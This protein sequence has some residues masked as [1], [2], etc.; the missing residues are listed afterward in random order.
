MSRDNLVGT[1][2]RACEADIPKDVGALI[3]GLSNEQV[4]GLW[5]GRFFPVW[6]AVVDGISGIFIPDVD[7]P[8]A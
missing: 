6:D 3:T 8:Y 1:I 5:G 2:M 4:Q 7:M